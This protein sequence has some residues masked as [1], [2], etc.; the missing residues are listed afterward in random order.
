MKQLFQGI[1]VK[2][3]LRL[4]RAYRFVW[5]AAPGWTLVSIALVTIQGALPLLTLYL[6]KLIIVLR[7]K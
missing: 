3:V 4:N 7:P 1:Q 2:E 5:H 6:M